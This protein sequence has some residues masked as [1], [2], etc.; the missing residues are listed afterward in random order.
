M[1]KL[2]MPIIVE[3]KYD[4]IK[5]SSLFDTA[6]ITT[7]GFGIFKDRQKAELI[8]TLSEKSGVIVLTDSDSAG[9]IIRSYLKNIIGEEK[10]HHVFLPEIKGKERRKNAPSREGL[11]GVEGV[12]PDIILKA[13]ERFL[14]QESAA[15][16]QETGNHP[17]PITAAFFME[18]GLSG[19]ENSAARRAY[20]LSRLGI[21]NAVSP[22]TLRRVLERVTTREEIRRIMEDY[23]EESAA[24]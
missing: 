15:S 18:C 12:S 2:D 4:K 7:D 16:Q 9:G 14:P 20:L 1:I 23:R 24:R 5:L 10:I 8:R 11:L 19:T 21:P 6:I 13:F 3:G 22:S 17:E